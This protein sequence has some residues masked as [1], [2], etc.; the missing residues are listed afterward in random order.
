MRIS[1]ER[2][3]GR[4]LLVAVEDAGPGVARGERVR[5]FERFA[6]GSAARHRV[7]TGLGLALVAEH[8]AAQGGEAWAEDRPG[9]GARFVVQVPVRVVAVR[10]LVG[11]A[12]VASAAA[13]S[14]QGAASVATAS[15]NRSGPTTSTGSTRP[16]P[17]RPRRPR[18]T[19]VAPTASL[20]AGDTTSTT[21]TTTST[22]ATEPVE[23]Y[24]VA[25]GVLES[26][27]QELTLGV[28]LEPGADRAR[29]RP[30]TA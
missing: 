29:V 17:R 25:G 20:P 4:H 24:F 26:V 27:S 23:L 16:R 28:T 3:D 18:P 12:I 8:A 5:I 11:V 1:I 10:R 2:G 6:R 19:T 13:R 30:A 7:G 22:I 14:S 9:G 15:S 21:G